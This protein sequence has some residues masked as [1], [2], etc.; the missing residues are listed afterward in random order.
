M[1][2]LPR[3]K[4]E[5]R[6]FGL[7][8]LRSEINRLF[9]SFFE[10][11]EL[12]TLFGERGFAPVMDMVETPQ[13]IQIRAEIPGMDA[14]SLDIS[15]SG[16]TLTLKGEKKSEREEKDENYYVMERSYGSFSRSVA[17]PSYADREKISADCKDGVLTIH[18]GKKEE[19]RGKTIQVDV[20]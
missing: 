2:L 13:E 8:G 15:V 18:V 14:K 11:R 10:G 9:D 5:S 16:D 7:P 12:P 19:A 3:K 17:L 20:K 4:D 1:A 6:S